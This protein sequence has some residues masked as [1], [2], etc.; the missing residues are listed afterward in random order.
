MLGPLIEE[1]IYYLRL[2]S[3]FHKNEDWATFL[4]AF[5]LISHILPNQMNQSHEVEEFW[6]NDG[7]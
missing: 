1:F 2:F 6:E 5:S 7:N 4:A 3:C